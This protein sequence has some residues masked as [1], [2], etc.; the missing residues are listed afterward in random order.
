M[1]RELRVV[2]W[3][4]RLAAERLL[5]HRRAER[6]CER[7]ER[8]P[9]LRV[10]RAGSGDDGRALGVGERRGERLDRSRVGR[11]R[12]HDRAGR[13]LVRP[14]VRGRQPV[15]HR[16]DDERRPT[17]GRRLV[18]RAGDGAGKILRAD[19]LVDPDGIVAGE[20][21]EPTG[22]ERLVR[23][24]TAVLLADEDDERR[25]VDARRGERADGVAEAGGRVEDRERG[26]RP[27]EG[28]PRCDPDDRP[29]VEREHEV[30]I[31]REPGQERHLRRARIR[32]HLR[33]L[34][35]A[36][37]VEDRITDGRSGHV[38]TLTQMI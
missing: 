17:G 9:A 10:V 21:V 14:V 5:P 37:N 4:P 36:K 35:F 2:A 7:D 15:V 24:V 22:E 28:I 26:L 18:P 1:P 31:V 3:E 33:E 30:E 20:P 8:G 29:L 6:L 11:C 32:E 23:E 25:P 12:T 34:P 38:S 19:R 27:A 16:R 13:R